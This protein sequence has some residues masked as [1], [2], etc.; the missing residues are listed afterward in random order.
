MQAVCALGRE[1]CATAGA[2]RS[3]SAVAAPAARQTPQL[4]SWCPTGV[5]GSP[6]PRPASRL[7]T[8]DLLFAAALSGCAAAE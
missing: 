4:P 3:S 6:P 7:P 8:W 1:R 5:E 2:E